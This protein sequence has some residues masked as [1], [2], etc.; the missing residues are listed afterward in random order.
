[1]RRIALI[2][3][4]GI[5]AVLRFVAYVILRVVYGFNHEQAMQVERQ[6]WRHA[7]TRVR[8]QRAQGNE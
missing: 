2:A 6:E 7:L 8:W 4:V 5:A 3:A 1:M